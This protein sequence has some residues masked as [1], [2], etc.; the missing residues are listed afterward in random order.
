MPSAEISWARIYFQ[1]FNI[2][3][4]KLYN[5]VDCKK[6]DHDASLK[7][8]MG[9]LGKTE[10]YR[11]KFKL[12][13]ISEEEFMQVLHT[14]NRLREIMLKVREIDPTHN[15]YVTYQELDDIIKMEYPQ[16]LNNRD[17]MHI[18][19]KFESMQNK[20]LIDYK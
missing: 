15:G 6:I 8:A 9:Y 17:I 16:Q 20:I 10:A 5:D 14:N 1:K 19:E 3:L 7:D 13:P 11:E 18:V 12:Y 4:E 2:I